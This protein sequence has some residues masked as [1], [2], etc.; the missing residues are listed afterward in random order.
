MDTH[1]LAVVRRMFAQAVF[2]HKVQEVAAEFKEKRAKCYKWVH[3]SLVLA[4]LILLG[5]QAAHLDSPIFAIMGIGVSIAEI[6]F[7]VIQLSFNI[8][9]EVISHKNSAFRY[10]EIRDE[11]IALIAD[12]MA[13]K[14]LHKDLIARRDALQRK[15][16]FICDMTPQTGEKEY[17]EAQRRLNKRGVVSGEQS[18]W[19]NAEI[20][21]FLP[22]ELRL[23]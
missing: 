3:I 18:S 8:E 10:I 16:Q 19:S 17:D 15:Y 22:E 13:G 9:R 4:V 23:S 20:D 14:V 1:N 12:I 21:H 6:G 2:T 11:Y 7:L 5:L